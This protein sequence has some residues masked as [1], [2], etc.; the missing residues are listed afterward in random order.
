[1]LFKKSYVPRLPLLSQLSDKHEDC[2][3]VSYC[4]NFSEIYLKLSSLGKQQMFK[5]SSLELQF[6]IQEGVTEA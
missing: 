4:S 6:N 5:N 1:M 3:H 2:V